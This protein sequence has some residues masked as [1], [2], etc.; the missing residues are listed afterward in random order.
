MRA[1]AKSRG[2]ARLPGALGITIGGEVNG[3]PDP[4]DERD[5]SLPPHHGGV[6]FAGGGADIIPDPDS[7]IRFGSDESGGGIVFGEANSIFGRDTYE[8]LGQAN[9][10]RTLSSAPTCHGG[11]NSQPGS[12]VAHQGRD[13]LG[14]AFH[15]GTATLGHTRCSLGAPCDEDCGYGTG[16]DAG[17]A[18]AHGQGSVSSDPY[19]GV[20]T[21]MGTGIAMVHG[22]VPGGYPG[23]GPGGG[24]QPG[25][26]PPGG[27]VAWRPGGN[28]KAGPGGGGGGG[29][30][31]SYGMEGMGGDQLNFFITFLLEVLGVLVFFAI[32]TIT[33]WITLG[34]HV[35]T[36]LVDLKNA[37]RNVQVAVGIIF[38][39]L[40]LAFAISM[41]TNRSGS[42]CHARD[43]HRYRSS[44]SSCSFTRHKPKPKPKHR[45]CPHK[46]AG[47]PAQHKC[48]KAASAE[49]RRSPCG[50]KVEHHSPCRRKPRYSDCEGRAIF[51]N[52]RRYAIPTEMKQ[53]PT[54][55]LWLRDMISRWM[56]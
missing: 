1:V 25:G 31:G 41:I 49:R 50:M 4:Q 51:I 40:L 35:V 13:T 6:G 12:T 43:R 30:R 37:E 10:G 46:P 34:Y 5:S 2:I 52:S 11:W 47:C 44:R 45:G 8:E 21:G 38:G 23:G 15:L 56:Q 28:F 55:V 36:L 18:T 16:C 17:C 54:M 32:C 53:P 7:H 20:V 9:Q 33:F 42:C 3:P 48:K 27:N 29:Q 39:V 24:G 26:Q 14:F 19:G 22:G